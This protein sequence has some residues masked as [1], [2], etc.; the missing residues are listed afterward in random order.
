[1]FYLIDREGRIAARYLGLQDWSSDEVRQE[2]TS[3]MGR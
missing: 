1:M 3:R 2:I